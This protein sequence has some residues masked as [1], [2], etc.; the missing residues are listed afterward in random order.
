MT[1]GS[2]G[3]G[4]MWKVCIKA[5]GREKA[6][7]ALLVPPV[8]AIIEPIQSNSMMTRWHFRKCGTEP[9]W[10]LVCSAWK[11]SC[12]SLLSDDVTNLTQAPG[13]LYCQWVYVWNVK[14]GGNDG[15][16]SAISKTF[17][18]ILFPGNHFLCLYRLE[19]GW[20][21]TGTLSLS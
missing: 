5:N 21:C 14:R 11:I 12:P 4:I 20:D 18:W 17:M 15:K 6:L 10:D 13:A 9:W 7:L 19:Q 8:A 3:H 2:H 16:S 1:W